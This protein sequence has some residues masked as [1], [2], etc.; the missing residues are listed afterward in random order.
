[1]SFSDGKVH[2]LDLY[3]SQ[4]DPSQTE[5]KEHH[6]TLLWHGTVPSP[7][8][9]YA[10]YRRI[11]A[12]FCKLDPQHAATY[13]SATEI[14]IWFGEPVPSDPSAAQ[15]LVGDFK[16]EFYNEQLPK[17]VEREIKTQL[18]RR[19]RDWK[20]VHI[21]SRGGYLQLV[22]EA[23]ENGE[24]EFALK[25]AGASREV[26]I[27]SREPKNLSA[28]PLNALADFIESTSPKAVRYE[29]TGT[30]TAEEHVENWPFS[31]AELEAALIFIEERWFA[32]PEEAIAA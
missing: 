10:H 22:A 27:I 30:D 8:A 3:Q 31:R 28:L 13:N 20:M 18:K 24:I 29:K 4:N 5:N 2:L 19:E 21:G 11:V 9:L 15:P 25:G 12:A 26:S 17:A 7:M 23:G 32:P 6:S 14:R 1:M 16:L